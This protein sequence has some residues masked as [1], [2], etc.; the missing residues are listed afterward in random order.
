MIP[1]VQISLIVVVA[2][3]FVTLAVTAAIVVVAYLSFKA[4]TN[5]KP[6]SVSWWKQKLEALWHSDAPKAEK[7]RPGLRPP[8]IGPPDGT[9]AAAAARKRR[10]LKQPDL[11][12]GQGPAV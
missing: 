9:D 1:R 4:K 11:E 10:G 8:D 3:E 5:W 6:V 7:A 12:E 2:T